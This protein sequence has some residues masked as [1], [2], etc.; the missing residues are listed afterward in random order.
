MVHAC[1]RTT[2]G[3]SVAPVPGA[4]PV[5]DGDMRARAPIGW[6]EASYVNAP[7]EDTKRGLQPGHVHLIRAGRVAN[8]YPQND[9]TSLR[10]IIGTGRLLCGS[11][12][13][14]SSRMPINF[15]YRNCVCHE[16]VL[17]AVEFHIEWPD[18]T[19]PDRF[20]A[21]VKWLPGIN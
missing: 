12:D 8:L 2:A 9:V 18:F 19:D 16:C 17:L 15:E 14:A 3:H 7:G 6:W 5:I 10:T 21:G 20:R 11:V 4:H 1:P 13:I